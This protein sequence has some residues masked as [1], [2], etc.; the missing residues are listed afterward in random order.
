[1]AAGAAASMEPNVLGTTSRQTPVM[2]AY[3]ELKQHLAEQHPTVNVDL[4]DIG[5][6]SESRQALMLEQL[7]QSKQAIADETIQQSRK[8]LELCAAESPESLLAAGLKVGAMSLLDWPASFTRRPLL[9]MKEL[10]MQINTGAN[11]YAYDG[12]HIGDISRVVIDPDTKAITHIVVEK[13]FLFTDDKVVSVD[14]VARA[15]EDGVTLTPNAQEL[16]EFPTFEETH[17]V[18]TEWAR[19]PPPEPAYAARTVY[20]YPPVGS[21]NTFGVNST[22]PPGPY[23]RSEERNIPEGTVALKEGASIMDRNGEHVGDL[24]R[25]YTDTQSDRATHLLISKGFLLKEERLIPTTWI[26]KVKEDEVHL[27]VDA[28]FIDELPEFEPQ[29]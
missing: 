16:D 1:M 28:Q 24:D 8:V 17:Y 6:A 3:N 22:Y 5:P 12:E 15:S 9:D 14:L 10:S 29:R 7:Q 25:I 2:D 23:L 26:S 13:G 4:L 18:P 27:S 21:W 20:W 19:T 11:V